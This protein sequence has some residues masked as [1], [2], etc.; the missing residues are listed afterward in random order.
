MKKSLLL[1]VFVLGFCYVKGQKSLPF[2][3][4]SFP[5]TVTM[6]QSYLFRGTLQFNAPA[7]DSLAGLLKLRISVNNVV[8]P[9]AIDSTQV[10]MSNGDTV[11]LEDITY[12]V[13]PSYFIPGNNIVV[14]WPEIPEPDLDIDSVTVVIYVIDDSGVDEA[15]LKENSCFPTLIKSGSHL[16]CQKT[17]EQVRIIGLDG[18]EYLYKKDGSSIPLNLA[19]GYYILEIIRYGKRHVQK[20]NVY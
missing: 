8:V 3:L 19:P 9:S 5:D 12:P 17:F 14:V 2:I 11:T 13:T 1:L 7:A 10:L 18:R 6:N 16:Y 4:S 15:R 20:I